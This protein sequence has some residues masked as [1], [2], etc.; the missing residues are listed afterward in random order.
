MSQQVCNGATL[1][2]SCGT[3][4]AKLIV[5]PKNKVI[6]SS[7]PAANIQDYIALQNIPSFGLCTTPSNPAVAAATAAAL[8]VLTPMPCVPNTASPWVA[9]I[10][11]VLIAGQPALDNKSKLT[12]M[13]GGTIQ[14]VEAGQMTHVFSG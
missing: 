13:Y 6:T 14:I 2:C 3:A 11:T 1:N 10:P 5:A 12:C 8:G 7:Q 4:S 9:G